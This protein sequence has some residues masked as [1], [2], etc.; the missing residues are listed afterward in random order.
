MEAIQPVERKRLWIYLALA[1]GISWAAGLLIFLRSQQEGIPVLDPK[2]GVNQ[3]FVVFLTL[4]M[5]SPAIA[6]VLTRLLTREGW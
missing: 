5:F 2:V 6:H 4:Y 3:S 1:F